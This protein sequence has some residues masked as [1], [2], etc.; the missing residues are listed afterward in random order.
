MN[1][2]P[3]GYCSSAP[4]EPATNRPRGGSENRE[5]VGAHQLVRLP[6]EGRP[7]SLA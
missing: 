2:W 6:G 3:T 7:Y 5:T 1:Q 4:T